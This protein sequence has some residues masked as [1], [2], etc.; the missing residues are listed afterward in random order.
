MLHLTVSR[1]PKPII[2]RVNGYY[3]GGANHL[4]YLCDF[5]IAAE[6]AIFGRPS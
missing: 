1:C 5:T 3:I 2:A 6:H 4:P